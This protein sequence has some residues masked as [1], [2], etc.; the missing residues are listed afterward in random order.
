MI[1]RTHPRSSNASRRPGDLKRSLI[2]RIAAVAVACF[3]LVAALTLL[4]LDRDAR[5]RAEAT[6][7]VVAKHLDFQL[8]RINAG[9]DLSNRYPDWDPLLVN[10]PASGQCVRLENDKGDI[11]RSTCT[12]TPADAV[13]APDWFAAT[14]TRLFDPAREA[15]HDVE[16]KG[17]RYGTVYV[18]SDPA[19]VTGEA[20]QQVRHLLLLTGLIV[21]TLSVFIYLAIARALAPTQDLIDGLDRLSD[22]DFSHR[23]PAF[24]LSELHRIGEV[25]NQLAAKIETTL[26]ERADLSRRLVNAQEEERRHLARELHDEFGQNLTA[27]AALAASIEKSA[28]PKCADVVEEAR[29]LSK[30]SAQ[31]M[32]ALR[33]TL[34]RLRPADLDKFGLVESLRQLVG[35]WRA[36]GSSKTR[37]ELDVPHEITPISDTAAVHIFRIAQEGL[38]NAAKH[39]DA[40]TVRLSVEPDRTQSSAIRLTIEDDGTGRRPKVDP[41]AMGILNMKERVAALGGDISFEDRPGSGL[42]VHVVVPVSPPA[43]PDTYQPGASL[44]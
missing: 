20:W 12:G 40:T 10:Y 24:K 33:G 42:T 23:L 43:G 7:E 30:I 14:Y 41:T 22:G 18:S 8:L 28:A 35:V 34:V 29:S 15:P 38:T 25:A 31:M 39:A 1:T 13:S 9:L 4:G 11:V 2:W 21:L 32:E 44:S 6:A 17:T 37:F 26:A 19:A 5:Q 3:A 16:Y 27:I 36:S